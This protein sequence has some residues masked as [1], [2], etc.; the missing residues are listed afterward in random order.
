MY[1][2]ILSEMLG[3]ESELET[4]YNKLKMSITNSKPCNLYL[5]GPPG[6]GK[7]A[8]VKRTVQTL[9]VT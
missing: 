7:T 2:N 4:L 9:E 1:I 6:T 3:R 5:S 8:C